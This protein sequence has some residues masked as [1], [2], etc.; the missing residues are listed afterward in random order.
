MY[1]VCSVKAYGV[2]AVIRYQDT[3]D[4]GAWLRRYISSLAART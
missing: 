2:T 1:A 4:K 3:P